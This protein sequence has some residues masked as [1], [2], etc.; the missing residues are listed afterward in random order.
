M[1]LRFLNRSRSFDEARCAIRFIGNDGL[2]E[3]P[4]FV[5]ASALVPTG[6]SR[7]SRLHLLAAF[8]AALISIRDVA[9]EAYSNDCRR[10][11][12]LT[13]ADFR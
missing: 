13:V 10:C 4:F 7:L 8:D 3:V 5:E 1:A 9:R 11:Y 12:V 6:I 2:R